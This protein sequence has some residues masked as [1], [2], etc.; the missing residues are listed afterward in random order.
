[1]KKRQRTFWMLV[2]AMLA[3]STSLRGVE[4]RL[5]DRV[6]L[7]AGQPVIVLRDLA[8]IVDADPSVVESFQRVVI[9]PAPAQGRSLEITHQLIF[10]RLR[11]SGLDL[12]QASFS[13]SSLTMVDVVAPDLPSS[14]VL[15]AGH[16]Q[17]VVSLLDPSIQKLISTQAP[18]LGA[19]HYQLQ[20]H[21]AGYLQLLAA[22]PRSLQLAI[23]SHD[24]QSPHYDISVTGTRADRQPIQVPVKLVIEPTP[25]VLAA[26]NDLQ[27]GQIIRNE[28]LA[29]LQLK[30]QQALANTHTN[31]QDLIGCEVTRPIRTNEPILSSQIRKSPLV[32]TGDIVTVSVALAGFSV[33]RQFKARHDAAKGDAVTLTTLDNKETISA[34]V[35]GFRTATLVDNAVGIQTPARRPQPQDPLELSL[36]DESSSIAGSGIPYLNAPS[37]N[38]QATPTPRSLNVPGTAVVLPNPVNTTPIFPATPDWQSAPLQPAGYLTPTSPRSLT[39]QPL[40]LPPQS[41]YQPTSNQGWK[42]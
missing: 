25:H 40:T 7:E 18:E 23:T 16:K 6:S 26:R 5:K 35:T 14:L 22:D 30:S 17:Q 15:N 31:P 11:S 38:F 34:Q 36:A 33:S 1:M 24:T 3:M 29:W 9:A 4:I 8:E 32:R 10:S 19:F 37:G 13:G 2:M 27:R 20:C 39:N 42:P 21:E 41:S 12:M 28:D